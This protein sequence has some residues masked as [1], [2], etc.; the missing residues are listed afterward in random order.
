MSDAYTN[1]Y[2]VAADASPVERGQF[3]RKVYLHTAGAIVAFAAVLTALY[4]SPVRDSLLQV[5]VGGK[6][7]WLI[8][9]AVFMGVSW[10][11]DK[12][13]NSNASKPMQ[14]LGLALFV[15]AE[16][17]IFLPIIT[18][19]AMQAPGLLPMAA[20]ITL[21]LTLGLTALVMITKVDF[22]F[23]RGV[24][25]I[26]G[27]I[28]MGVIVASII[29]GFTLGILF[30]TIMV[31]FAGAAILYNTSAIFRN[32]GTDQYV[33]A[34]LSLFASI[35]LLFFWILRLLMSLRR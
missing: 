7:S 17:V 1:P 11:A 10:I 26:G 32:Y 33:A 27:F 16:A 6:Y 30:A 23:L 29:F 13:A 19:A 24:L 3:I 12:W 2:V 5:M 20:C 35:A 21:S 4:H 9:L 22:S 8:V 15:V 34:S 28:A 25:F 14:Y 31:A 18:I